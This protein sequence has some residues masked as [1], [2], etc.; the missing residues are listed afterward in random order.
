MKLLALTEGADHVCFRYRVAAFAPELARRGWTV[1]AV[2]L[3]KR[4]GP[5]SW[6]LH[7]VA[8]AD[9]V[10]L[11]RRLL[12][13]WQLSLLRRQ[14]R[15]LIYDFDDALFYRDSFA[16][17]GHASWLRL[18]H[19]WSTVYTAD[20]VF[21]GN[22][23]LAREASLL[24]GPE[25]VLQLPTCVSPQRYALAAHDRQEGVR[26][27]WIGQRSTLPCLHHARPL[28]AAAGRSAPDAVLRIICDR[29]LA[30]E[31]PATEFR[32]WSTASEAADLSQCDIGVS[33][34]PDDPWSQGKC[35]LK[36]LQYMAAGLPVVA[37]SVGLNRRLVRH[38][39]TGFLADTPAEW[40]AA[41]RRLA[42]DPSL[43]RAMGQAGRAVIE[44]QFNAESWAKRFAD[45]VERVACGRSLDGLAQVDATDHA[46]SQPVIQHAA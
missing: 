29:P 30:L 27:V 41:V 31:L 11:Q 14:A 32:P 7:R 22:D 37:N 18:G 5:R 21:A 39:E 33:Y 40:A 6:Q 10:L 35:G 23:F 3:S 25:K 4:T 28:L 17:K 38:G 45:T 26:M 12:P 8:D 19:F 42:D 15:K 16:A 2:P 9:V 20:A 46:T 44:R 1:E 36:V 13:F 34:L 43:R 24:V